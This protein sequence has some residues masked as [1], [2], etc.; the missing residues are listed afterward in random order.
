[1]SVHPLFSTARWARHGSGEAAIRGPRDAR[2]V[3]A[4]VAATIFVLAGLLASGAPAQAKMPGPNGRIAFA[5]FDTNIGDTV[6]YTANPDG[7]Q[8]QRLF[9]G[10]SGS[11]RWSPDGT[12]VVI[13]SCADPPVCDTAAVIV[14]PDTGQYRILTA[15]DPTRLFVGCDVWAADGQRLACEGDGQADPGLNGIY[16]IR[17]SDGRGLTR[18][19]SNPGGTDSPIDYSPSGRQLVF[20]RSVPTRPSNS[21]NS[22]LF[23]VNTDGT[24]LHRIT[25]WGF[26][27]DDGSWSPDGT[28]I[29]F[30]H[31]RA[32]FVVHPDGSCL[33]KVALATTP[34]SSAG[35]FSW[36][37]D[38]TKILFLLINPNGQEGMATANAN[39]SNVQ[40]ITNSP[41]SDSKG[42]WG[43]HPLVS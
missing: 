31:N 18:V 21:P 9:P 37:P 22:A 30:E 7:T 17:T 36:S 43:P 11:P 35:D 16:T 39:G 27:D 10:A 42:D 33:T 32:L 29:A 20:V 23:V 13:G 15:P 3:T 12:Q 38:G 28:E 40:R 6:T 41:T 1:M 25:P 26:S 34:G 4:V 24:D 14:N 5:R 19:T 2:R 8:Q